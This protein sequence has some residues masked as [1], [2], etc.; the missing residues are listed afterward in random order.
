MYKYQK[1]TQFSQGY[2]DKGSNFS[3]EIIISLARNNV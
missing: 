1:C 2:Q 3:I